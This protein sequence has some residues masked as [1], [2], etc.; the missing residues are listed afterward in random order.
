MGPKKS[1]KKNDKDNESVEEDVVTQIF[2]LSVSGLNELG[3][4]VSD[5]VGGKKIKGP[6]KPPNPNRKAPNASGFRYFQKQND[7]KITALIEKDLKKL[8]KEDREV[9]RKKMGQLKQKKASTLWKELTKEEKD[10]YTK[11]GTIIE[12]KAK[13][14]REESSSSKKDDEDEDEDE[15][16]DDTEEEDE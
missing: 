5:I 13:K 14:D 11:K 4:M 7:D 12:E 8:N 3:K 1:D 15:D 2:K 16:D 10:S 9:Q 6:K